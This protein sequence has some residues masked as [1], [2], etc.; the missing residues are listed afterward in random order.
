[1][2]IGVGLC[3][4]LFAIVML[5]INDFVAEEIKLKVSDCCKQLICSALLHADATVN[6]S[7]A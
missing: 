4:A 7:N 2:L 5:Y 3:I 1:M 6:I